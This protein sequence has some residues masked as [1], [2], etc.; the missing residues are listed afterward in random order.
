LTVAF[1]E[2]RNG[3]IQVLRWFSQ[4]ENCVTSADDA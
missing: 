1:V 4:F 3:T 2:H